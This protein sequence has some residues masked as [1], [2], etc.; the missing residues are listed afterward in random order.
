VKAAGAWGWRPTILAVPNVKKVQGLNLPGTPFG[1][2]GLLCAW[3]ANNQRNIGLLKFMQQMSETFK[4][5]T[6]FGLRCVILFG[7]ALQRKISTLKIWR[8]HWF[9]LLTKFQSHNPYLRLYPSLFGSA[10]VASG[11]SYINSG[12]FRQDK[13]FFESKL[14][15]Y[16]HTLN[17]IT[18]TSLTIAMVALAS[19]QV[20]EG[21]EL[22]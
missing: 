14:S 12:R 20:G 11:R 13:N 17:V 10:G 9:T 7:P 8:Q 1:P 15:W 4:E 6:E 18:T 3:Q 2:C 16:I 21:R 19:F 5:S 22:M